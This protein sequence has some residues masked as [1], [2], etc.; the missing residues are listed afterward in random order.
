MTGSGVIR[1]SVSGDASCAILRAMPIYN[2]KGFDEHDEELF[3]ERCEAP[4]EQIA[5]LYI[6]AALRRSGFPKILQAE[7]AKRFEVKKVR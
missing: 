3:D 2:V 5:Q 7:K 1:R 6:L 4:N